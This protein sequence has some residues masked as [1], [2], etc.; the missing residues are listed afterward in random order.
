[1]EERLQYRSGSDEA[2]VEPPL[3]SIPPLLGVEPIASVPPEREECPR[4]VGKTDIKMKQMKVMYV[5]SLETDAVDVPDDGPCICAWSNKMIRLV[6]DLDTKND[7]SFGKLPLKTCFRRRPCL[8]SAEPH[9][10]DMFIKCHAPVNPDEEQLEIYRTAVTSM[11]NFFE[12]GLAKFIRSL[13]DNQAKGGANIYV[14]EEKVQHKTSPKRKR[15]VHRPESYDEGGEHQDDEPDNEAH[16]KTA[17]EDAETHVDEDKPKKRK[18]V[19][20]GVCAARDS[21]KCKVKDSISIEQVHVQE[22]YSKK[23]VD[24]Q[25]TEV[26]LAGTVITETLNSDVKDIIITEPVE[27][28][29]EKDNTSAT[30][31]DGVTGSTFCDAG[32]ALKHLQMYATG[33]PSSTE[34]PNATKYISGEQV[35]EGSKNSAVAARMALAKSKKSVSFADQRIRVVIPSNQLKVL[36]MVQGDPLGFL[37]LRSLVLDNPK[38]HLKSTATTEVTTNVSSSPTKLSSFA[39]AEVS[40]RQDNLKL[41]SITPANAG[42]RDVPGSAMLGISID[43]NRKLEFES[44]SAEGISET[45]HQRK[46]RDLVQDCP[47]FD[48]GFDNQEDGKIEEPDVA[49]EEIVVISSNEDSGDSLDKIY[50]SIELHVPTPS[51]VKGKELQKEDV[52]PNNPNSCTP[53][54]QPRR[55]VK[56]GPKQK[57]PYANYDKKPTVPRSDAELYNKVCAYGGRSKHPLNDEKIIDY[58]NFYIYLRDLANSIKPEGWLSNSTCEIA[59]RVLSTEMAKQKKF[60][61]PLRIATR[62]RDATCN[63]DR[64]VKKAFECTPTYRLDH[65]DLILFAVLQD[66]T[67]ESKEMTGHYYLIVL[68]LKAGRFELMDSMREG[69]KGMM[70]DARKIIGSIKH[71]WQT[72][73]SDSKIDISKYKIVHIPT[74]MQKTTYD[75]GYFVLKFIESWDGRRMLPFNP[76]DMHALRKLFL[77]KWM[78]REENLVNWDEMLFHN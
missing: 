29:K 15:S 33:S 5:D 64:S 17:Q 44:G 37:H 14:K 54:P 73:Y 77:K 48:L 68:N 75:C 63:L 60:V 76:S 8:F 19:R 9:V 66:L 11:C 16:V 59:L 67:P 61:M 13:A 51:T 25:S 3:Q 55:V 62:L 20:K 28:N 32:D 40:A 10:V 18:Y 22:D 1:M 57:L 53:V 26:E 71:Y 70:A 42:G 39:T 49:T 7:G 41:T 24:E 12:D 46:I 27:A 4:D 35:N 43:V 74:P 52:S 23:M 30:R 69:D 47:S 56:L 78:V 38:C 36:P 45:V 2:E 50:A 65:K 58:G 21:K 34:T 72:N 6:V 31:S